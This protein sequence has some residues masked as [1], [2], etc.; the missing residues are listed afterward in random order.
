MCLSGP[1]GNIKPSLPLLPCDLSLSLSPSLQFARPRC[2]TTSKNK[3]SDDSLQVARRP[4]HLYLR[5][6]SD[7]GSGR[8]GGSCIGRRCAHCAC[9]RECTLRAAALACA[10]HCEASCGPAASCCTRRCR[11]QRPAT[12]P[13]W[14]PCKQKTGPRMVPKVAQWPRSIAGLVLRI[15]LVNLG[16][17]GNNERLGRPTIGGPR[18]SSKLVGAKGRRLTL[19]GGKFNGTVGTNSGS[20]RYYLTSERQSF[21]A[22]HNSWPRLDG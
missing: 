21:G 1:A 20:K 10:P 2:T 3:N 8:R 6:R 15:Q 9:V 12:I 17:G 13:F 4:A 14:G 7:P 19:A 11:M 18:Q 22:G 16:G 5:S